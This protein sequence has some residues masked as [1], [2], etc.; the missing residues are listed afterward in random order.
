MIYTQCKA[1]MH[2]GICKFESDVAA[3]KENI[4]GEVFF[5]ATVNLTVRGLRPSQIIKGYGI[6]DEML[7]EIANGITELEKEDENNGGR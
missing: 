2:T 1:C 7:A 4:E 3:F 5:P 6:S